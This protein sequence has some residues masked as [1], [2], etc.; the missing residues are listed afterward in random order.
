MKKETVKWS[1]LRNPG[2]TILT[3]KTIILLEF[4]TLSKSI[5]Y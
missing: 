3:I 4:L 5:F 1:N 2:Q